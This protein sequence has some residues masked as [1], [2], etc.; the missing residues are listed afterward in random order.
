MKEIRKAQSG[1]WN[2]L[3]GC[4]SLMPLLEIIMDYNFVF[5]PSVLNM[6]VVRGVS[7]E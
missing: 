7:H 5:N 1:C 4:P 2:S 3:I 6:S